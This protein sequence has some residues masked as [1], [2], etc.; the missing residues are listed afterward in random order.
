MARKVAVEEH[1]VCPEH[2]EYVST[3]WMSPEMH[4][5]MIDRLSDIG[6]RRLAEMDRTGIELAVLSLVTEG[7]QAEPDAAKAAAKASRANDVLAAIIEQYPGR[8]SGLAAVSLRDVEGAA[9]ELRR[10][11]T[12][13]GLVGVCVNGF[14]TVDG[15][16]EYYDDPKFLPF[17]QC[18]AEL[19]VPLYLHPRYPLPSQRSIYEGR[20][21]LLG[22][23]WGFGVE[24]ATHALRLIT[25]GL[26]DRVPGATVILGH[27]G[28]TL[29]FTLHRMQGRMK[30]LRGSTLAR[31]VTE[32]LQ[33][34]FYVATSGN[35]HTPTLLGALLELGSERVLF[36]VD[37]PFEEMSDAAT[38]FDQ[39][40]IA[41]AD[42]EKIGAGNARRLLKLDQ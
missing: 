21:E 37:Y 29:P 20:P 28:E 17:W 27:L 9:K 42:R 36:A 7:V 31:P 12:D 4:G 30:A 22:S 8:F 40:P 11:I 19:D 23:T 33:E 3:A 13:L 35:F 16:G 32:Y 38:W 39:L 5:R 25:S 10:A 15:G 24:T 1:F 14:T 41:P 6:D 26:F 34:N 18:L 2:E